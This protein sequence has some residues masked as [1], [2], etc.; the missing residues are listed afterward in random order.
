MGAKAGTLTYMHIWYCS[1]I[2]AVCG[3]LYVGLKIKQFW[4]IHKR[5]IFKFYYLYAYVLNMDFK[6]Q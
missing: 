3:Q 5:I 6:M 4:L 2:Y 1:Y